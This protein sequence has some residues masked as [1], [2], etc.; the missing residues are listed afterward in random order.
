[1]EIL[2]MSDLQ[3]SL[4]IIGVIVIAG[5]VVFNWVQ[6]ERYRRKVEK[7]FEQKHEDVLFKTSKTIKQN[8]RIEPQFDKGAMSDI[9]LDP[10][11][12]VTVTKSIKKSEPE[13]ESSVPEVSNSKK[14]EDANL[15]NYVACVR[16]N[17]PIPETQLTE[18]LHRKFDF[19]KAVRWFGQRENST[20]WVEFPT[21]TDE[22]G[23][24][25]VNLK[26]C[27]QLVDRSGPV[28]EVNLSKFRDLVHDFA[29]HTN[30]DAD[31][32]DI[33]TAHEHAVS[34]DKFCANV[35]VVIGINI[36]SRDKGAFIGTKIRALAEASGFKLETDGM[37]KYFDE[38]DNVLFTLHN[39]E[40]E[41]FRADNMKSLT[42]R[43]ITFLLD[44]PRVAN[45][46]KVFDQMTHIARIFTNT[47][48]G[49]MVDDNRVPLTDNGIIR[50]RQQLSKIQSEMQANK[51]PAGSTNAMKLFV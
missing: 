10:V 2:N 36:I 49:I 1:M 18:L 37:F 35:D 8:E 25:Y 31:C 30:S 26:G 7:A 13:N 14:D 17:T 51:I 48:G 24:S 27:L 22:Y 34:L 4:I 32:P 46:E 11:N 23:N 42:T 3:I 15:I 12:P 21:E 5:V 20:Q 39:H 44:V 29:N 38:N 47:L 50:S 45:G 40:N 33:S 19:G 9:E 41:P 28:T 43:G 16:S 6:Q